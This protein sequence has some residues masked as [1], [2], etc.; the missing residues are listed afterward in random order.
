MPRILDFFDG[1]SSASA[2]VASIAEASK[3]GVFASDA[4]FEANK[5]SA[6]ADGDVYLNSTSGVLRRYLTSWGD[7]REKTNSTAANPT[8]SNDNTEGYA[9]FSLWHNSSTNDV[10]IAVD[11]STGAAVWDEL[12]LDSEYSVHDHDGTNSPQILGTDIDS[13]GGT[14]TQ[15]LTADGAGNATWEDATGGSGGQGLP[16]FDTKGDADDAE[17]AD[18]T[19]SGL[20]FSLSTTASELIEGAQVFKA[21]STA[22]S[23]TVRSN[24]GNMP[25]PQGLR[26]R[27]LFGAFEYKG[28]ST[29]WTFEVLESDVTTVLFSTTI[30]SFTA[31][32]DESKKF[33]YDFFN[34]E[35]NDDLVYRF[36]SSAADTLLWDSHIVNDL[37]GNALVTPLQ[38]SQTLEFP[39]QHNN[40]QNAAGEVRFEAGLDT[41]DFVGDVILEVEDDAGN[42]RTKFN[43]TRPCVV[44]ITGS[45][46]FNNDN[47]L[48]QIF[49]NGTVIM[50]GSA[51]DANATELV[52]TSIKLDTGDFLSIGSNA[53]VSSSAVDGYLNI[54][55]RADV[56]H[57]IT[58]AKSSLT[59]W[60]QYTPTFSGYGTVT[61]IDFWY[62]RL[63]DSIQIMGK[64]TTGTVAASEAQIGLPSV[65]GVQY[66]VDSTVVSTVRASGEINLNQGTANVVWPLLTGGD[67]FLNIGVDTSGQLT[68]ANANAIHGSSEDFSVFA[69]VPIDE[70]DTSAAFLASI[71]VQKVAVLTN[72]V[73]SGTSVAGAAAGSY[74]TRTLNTASGDTEILTLSANQFTLGTGKYKIDFTG[75]VFRV[76]AN[77]SKIRNITDS[78]DDI[79]GT[80]EFNDTGSSGSSSHGSGKLE[81]TSAKTFELQTRV[82]VLNGTD[83][84]GRAASFGDSEVYNPVT[85]T[86]IE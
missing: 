80:A 50:D 82:G 44:D 32:G 24:V 86:K 11:V 63:G 84:F 47:E 2:P 66:T 7:V 61:N 79:I 49:K 17:L 69:D 35:D 81:L 73:S 85:I 45:F 76:D 65:G 25:V 20:T 40:L 51:S 56:D 52:S 33:T 5:G 28:N 27:Q 8:V 64:A 55:A 62:R 15:V 78:T 30:S 3:F 67:A 59:E 54:A 26:G 83:G 21:V 43:A 48:P 29:D 75:T 68:P 74:A 60:I 57:I 71:P 36:T 39:F 19:S 77:K 10:F 58:P 22:S 13:T 41:A 12:I 38:L 46:F 31:T 6:G 18:F 4:A 1:Q 23:E 16:N 34:P 72:T 70:L 42:T 14:N 53:S 37:F 9:V